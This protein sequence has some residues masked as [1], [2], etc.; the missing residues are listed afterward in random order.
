MIK[1]LKFLFKRGFR[2]IWLNITCLVLTIGLLI[3]LFCFHVPIGEEDYLICKMFPQFCVFLFVMLSGIF[4]CTDIVGNR[5]MR[6]APMSK[7]MRLYSIPI[8]NTIVPFGFATI[9]NLIY[10]VYLFIAGLDLVHLSD[11]L[12]LSAVI[13]GVMTIFSTIGMNFSFGMLF[14]IYAY[15]PLF[16]A[17]LFL[18]D[19]VW[20]YGFGMPLWAALLIYLG[21][22]AVSSGISFIIAR[23]FYRYGEFKPLMQQTM[24][25]A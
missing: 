22:A 10:V 24:P 4:L 5:A 23:L 18:S 13:T 21:V 16:A 14:M 19:N 6:S 3:L 17:N 25:N 15:I 8:Y 20:E 12:I 9:M 11:M 1:G 2:I 7:A